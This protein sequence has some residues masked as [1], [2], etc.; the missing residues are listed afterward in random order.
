M[1]V[2]PQ[3]YRISFVLNSIFFPFIE[4]DFSDLLKEKGYT[5]GRSM[6]PVFPHGQRAYISGRIALKDDCVVDVDSN[7]K[8]V[9]S[10]GRSLEDV[11]TTM[12]ELVSI[13]TKNFHVNLKKELSFMELIADLI[14]T[15]ER[16]P[17][18]TMS[19]FSSKH[20]SLEKFNEIMGS[21]TSFVGI[22]IG[23][24]GVDPNNPKWFDIKVIPHHIA[25]SREYYVQAIFRE[26]EVKKVLDFARGIN[27]RVMNLIKVIERN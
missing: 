2:E 21:E 13:S 8:L 27:T 3:R 10:E 22:E 25:S 12:E 9:A 18:R 17:L 11:I 7:R 15:S 19:E 26:K 5:L 4:P 24:K 20:A 1:R 23:P 14:V 16:N 6:V